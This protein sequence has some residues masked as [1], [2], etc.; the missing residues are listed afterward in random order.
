MPGL[1]E[2]LLGIPAGEPEDYPE[3]GWR[4]TS[5]QKLAFSP[6]PGK[7]EAPTVEGKINLYWGERGEA[8]HGHAVWRDGNLEYFRDPDG[9]VH[10]DLSRGIR[11]QPWDDL[12]N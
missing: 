11:G 9:E 10:R 12:G 6:K 3:G 5:F 8:K 7:G 4:G 1:L 2:W